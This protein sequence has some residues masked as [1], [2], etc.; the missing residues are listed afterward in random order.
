MTKKPTRY[1]CIERSRCHSWESAIR[2]GIVFWR[3]DDEA[4][5][6]AQLEQNAR[7]GLDGFAVDLETGSGT[8]CYYDPQPCNWEHVPN[9]EELKGLLLSSP[10]AYNHGCI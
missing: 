1:V 2:D 4:E 9:W 3:T 8:S 6:M 5:A 7:Y 10:S